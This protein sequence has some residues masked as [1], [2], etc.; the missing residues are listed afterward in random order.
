MIEPC[1]RCGAEVVGLTMSMFNIQ[2]ICIKCETKEKEHPDYDKATTAETA[3]LQQGN[4]DF[5]GIGLPADLE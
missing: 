3:E 5:E 4:Y 2:M 1:E